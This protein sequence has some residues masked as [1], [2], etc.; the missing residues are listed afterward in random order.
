[1]T[2]RPKV[3]DLIDLWTYDKEEMVRGTI[4]SL[5]D[6]GLYVFSSAGGEDDAENLAWIT[7]EGPAH[8]QQMDL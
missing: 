6:A 7:D 4:T 2:P 1:M 3:G 8:W 5:D